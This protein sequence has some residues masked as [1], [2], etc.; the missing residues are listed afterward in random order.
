[1]LPLNP[2][3]S[4]WP[5]D[6]RPFAKRIK[7]NVQGAERARSF[8]FELSAAAIRSE[9]SSAMGRSAFPA[10]WTYLFAIAKLLS[11]ANALRPMIAARADY[12]SR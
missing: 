9:T 3:A 2:I 7:A 1:M 5:R 8:Y 4:T 6:P 11:P 12:P 10:R